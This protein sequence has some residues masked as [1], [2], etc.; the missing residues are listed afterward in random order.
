M[1]VEQNSGLDI[2][3]LDGDLNSSKEAINATEGSGITASFGA[4][5]GD[6]VSFDYEFGTNDYIPIKTSLSSQ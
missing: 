5:A 2:G 6:I 4:N 1:E 3:A